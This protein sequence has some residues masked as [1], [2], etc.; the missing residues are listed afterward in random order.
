[1]QL[2]TRPTGLHPHAAYL[3]VGNQTIS[4]SEKSRGENKTGHHN[5]VAVEVGLPDQLQ[6]TQ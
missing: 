5:E 1:M 4:N 2:W 3:P 6:G